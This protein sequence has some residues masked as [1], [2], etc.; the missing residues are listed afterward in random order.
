MRFFDVGFI[1]KYP[2]TDFHEMNLDWCIRTVKGLF[3]AV[4]GIN[5]WIENH[6]QEYEQ[7]KQL[8]DAVMSGN[9][10]DPIKQAF[11][12]WMQQNALDIVGELATSVFFG[13][14]DSGYFV[15]YIPES[16][17]DVTFNTSGLDTA[18]PDVGYGHLVLSY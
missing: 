11:S 1:N 5:G 12:S 4:H 2:Y 15:A 16:W 7:L 8:Y 10:P 13:L 6:E 14:T 17:D 9:F 3:E 18:V